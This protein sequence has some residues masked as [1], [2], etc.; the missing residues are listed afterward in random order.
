L[1]LIAGEEVC[2]GVRGKH[3][4]VTARTDKEIHPARQRSIGRGNCKP[5]W[6]AACHQLPL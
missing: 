4:Q 5:G 3:G 6:T 2:A 1:G